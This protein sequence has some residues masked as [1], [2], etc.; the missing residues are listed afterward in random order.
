MR[1]HRSIAFAEPLRGVT[2]RARTSPEAAL[3]EEILR[4]REG[5]AYERGLLDGEKRL[6]EQMLQQRSELQHLQAGVLASLQGA[7]VGVIRETEQSLLELAFEIACKLVDGLP[8]D[9][10]RVEASVKSALSAVSEATQIHVHLHPE[11]LQVL[12]KHGSELLAE[13][14]GA[15]T[16][17]FVGDTTIGRGGSLVRTEFGIID[18]QPEARRARVRQ[19][20][21]PGKAAVAGKAVA[22]GRSASAD[23]VVTGDEAVMGDASVPSEPAAPARKT[24]A[25]RK[26]RTPRKAAAAKKGATSDQAV[27]EEKPVTDEKAVAEE[28]ATAEGTATAGDTAVGEGAS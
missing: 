15:R 18:A 17:R 13:D 23:E 6:G 10:E 7:V 28:K 26:V 11:D 2:L 22:A 19:A 4:E 16:I 8:L 20:V 14:S 3:N 21:T 24:G 9:R 25:V 5:R 12:R 27:V 1:L